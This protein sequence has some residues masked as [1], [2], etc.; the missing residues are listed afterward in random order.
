MA[1][2]ETVFLLEW[3]PM[4]IFRFRRTIDAAAHSPI[5]DYHGRMTAAHSDRPLA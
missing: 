2:R 5:I 1:R 4:R 3:A